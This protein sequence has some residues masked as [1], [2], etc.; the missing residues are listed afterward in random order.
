MEPISLPVLE[1]CLYVK[2]IIDQ[3][4]EWKVTCLLKIKARATDI[5]IIL[6]QTVVDRW[7]SALNVYAQT[8]VRSSLEKLSVGTAG[9]QGSISS[10][11]ASIPVTKLTDASGKVGPWRG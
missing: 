8:K 7:D 5:I 4:T 11:R 9:R 2:K 10:S 1:G 6:I 3:Q